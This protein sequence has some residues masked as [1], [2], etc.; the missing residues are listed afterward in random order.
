MKLLFSC[1]HASRHV[2]RRHA[3]LF[4]GHEKVLASHRGWDPGSSWLARR[5]AKAFAAPLHAASVTRLLVDTNR[6][7]RH[8][9]LFSPFSASLSD[10]ER[11]DILERHYHPHRD[12]IESHLRRLMGRGAPVLHIGV[13]SFTPRW[14]NQLRPCDVGLLYDPGRPAE[15]ALCLRWQGLLTQ[16]APEL[17]VRRNYP[18][19]GVADGFTTHLRRV[20]PRRLYAGIELELNQSWIATPGPARLRLARLVESSLRS[21]LDTDGSPP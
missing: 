14:R 1:E 12:P 13:H 5:L 10:G 16:M 3:A 11:R 6:S 19:R 4:A 20:L 7:L 9:N 2:P 21:A 17:R 18:Y 8:P 15:L